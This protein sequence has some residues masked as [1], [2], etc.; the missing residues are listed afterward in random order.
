MPMAKPYAQQAVCL[1]ITDPEW[2]RNLSAYAPGGVIDEVNFWAPKAQT[3][4]KKLLP[5]EPVFFK[6]KSP[7][8]AVAGYGFFASWAIPTIREAWLIFGHKNGDPT[9]RAFYERFAS[10]RQKPLEQLDVDC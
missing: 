7:Y 8:N 9:E 3:P 4:P 5:G 6:L 1:A 2:F 10:M